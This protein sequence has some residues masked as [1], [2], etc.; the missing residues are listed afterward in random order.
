MAD[1]DEAREARAERLRERIERLK[2]G[3]SGP[4]GEPESPRAFVERRMR[5]LD[6]KNQ[7]EEHGPPAEE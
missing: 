1:D 5:E 3:S 6:G 4:A 7:E 2:E